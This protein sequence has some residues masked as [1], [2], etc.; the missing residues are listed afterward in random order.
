MKRWHLKIAELDKAVD[1]EHDRM[2][3]PDGKK[4]P[5]WVAM[6]RSDIPPGAKVMTTK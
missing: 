5:V 4:A 2:I 1:E 3:P 6:K